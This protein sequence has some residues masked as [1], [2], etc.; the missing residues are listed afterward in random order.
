MLAL[1]IRMGIGAI[2]MVGFSKEALRN[3]S[4]LGLL[5]Y[6][7]VYNSIW[8]TVSSTIYLRTVH[9]SVLTIGFYV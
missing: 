8:E 2:F 1:V 7:V 5:G 6:I 9:A 3:S 4:G